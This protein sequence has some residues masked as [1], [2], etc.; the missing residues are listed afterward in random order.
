PARLQPRCLLRIARPEA[1]LLR[2]R[3]VHRKRRAPGAGAE[4]RDVHRRAAERPIE[5]RAPPAE[6]TMVPATPEPLVAPPDWASACACCASYIPWK[7]TSES[8]PG[9][10][11]AR[12]QMSETMARSDG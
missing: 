6:L 3:R 5:A 4:H 11:P 7:L 8:T 10:K 12:V 9:G 2:R 1:H